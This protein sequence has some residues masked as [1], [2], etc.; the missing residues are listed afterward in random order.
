M[1]VEFSRPLRIDHIDR[2]GKK[3]TIETNSEEAAALAERFDLLSIESMSADFKVKPVEGGT[4]YEV[5]GHLFAK[6]TQQ[7]IVSGLPVETEVKQDILAWYADY[8]RVTSFEKVKKQRERE[9]IEDEREIKSEEDDPE[10]IVNGA[11]DLGEVAAQFL[12][13]ALDEFPRG[14]N[15]EIGAGDYIEVK[16]EE[17]KD[18]PFAALAQLKDKKK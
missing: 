16:P 6:V 13:L 11:I 8:E 2:A 17:T 9:D 10:K 1:I 5:T 15:E 12:G 3:I 14:E 7:S 4:K 18:N